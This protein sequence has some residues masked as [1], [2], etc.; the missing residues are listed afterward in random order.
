MF[1]PARCT[2]ITEISY[3]GEPDANEN[4]LL[5]LYAPYR[6]RGV[7]AVDE[8]ITVTAVTRIF[9]S[10][11]SWFFWLIIVFF[12]A[13]VFDYL[14]GTLAARKRNEW[15][16]TRAREGLYHKLGI[17]GALILSL[18]VDIVIGLAADRVIR[19]P[20][21][22]RGLFSPLCAVWYIVTEFGSVTENLNKLGAKIPPFLTRGLAMLKS[23]AEQAG[24]QAVNTSNE[25]AAADGKPAGG[26]PSPM[27]GDPDGDES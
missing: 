19:L 6:E 9:S 14:T 22:F 26:M 5:L 27:P 11:M 7:K 16:S 12:A 2:A 3:H 15:S 24:G 1:F 4:L 8:V 23:A 21:R 18:L 10:I 20:F 17:A 13:M 25:G